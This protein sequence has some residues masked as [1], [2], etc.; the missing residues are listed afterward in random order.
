MKKLTQENQVLINNIVDN[1]GYMKLFLLHHK[2]KIQSNNYNDNR[3]LIE[4]LNNNKKII[5]TIKEDIYVK[6]T[7]LEDL[8]NLN[9]Y[10]ISSK[11]YKKLLHKVIQVEEFQNNS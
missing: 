5:E 1:S 9:L 6:D 4:E 10:D 11:E 3:K 7:V 2:S 8:E